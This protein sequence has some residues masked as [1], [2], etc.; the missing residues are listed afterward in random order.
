MPKGNR[1]TVFAWV[2]RMSRDGDRGANGAL[3]RIAAVC[4]T[5]DQHARD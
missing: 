3:Y 2:H 5:G 4:L 1:L